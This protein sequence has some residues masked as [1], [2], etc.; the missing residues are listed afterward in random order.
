MVLPEVWVLNGPTATWSHPADDIKELL[1]WA[2]FKKGLFD[3]SETS[4]KRFYSPGDNRPQFVGNFTNK[5]TSVITGLE[6]EITMR[7][8]GSS[9]GNRKR[10]PIVGKPVRENVLGTVYHP[11][12][13]GMFPLSL[14]FNGSSDDYEF[15]VKLSR[16][17]VWEGPAV[18]SR[19]IYINENMQNGYIEE[20][21]IDKSVTCGSHSNELYVIPSPNES[22]KAMRAEVAA[23][24]HC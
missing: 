18:A 13:K 16:V 24:R 2:S 9:A 5:S 14:P 7:N 4:I 11:N 1:K 12:D 23:S 20:S 15:D 8:C 17:A 6:F 10:C 21:N 3:I 19:Y 22:G